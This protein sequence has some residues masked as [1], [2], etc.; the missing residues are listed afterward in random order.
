MLLGSNHLIINRI[1]DTEI[2]NERNQNCIVAKPLVK[3]YTNH[4]S[5]QDI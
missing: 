2:E 1:S 5:F 3:S 4:G